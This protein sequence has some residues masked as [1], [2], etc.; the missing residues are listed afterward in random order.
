MAIT[1]RQKRIIVVGRNNTEYVTDDGEVF[2][3][4]EEAVE[5]ENKLN[6]TKA[7]ATH[8]NYEFVTSIQQAINTAVAEKRV[9]RFI[10]NESNKKIKESIEDLKG[11]KLVKPDRDSND[12]AVVPP[13]IENFDFNEI[14]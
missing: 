1:P 7:T 12:V 4:L 5:H 11:C 10:W 2:D 9:V 3:D 13:N 6:A 8:A 14:K